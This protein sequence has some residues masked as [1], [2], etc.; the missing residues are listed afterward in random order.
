MTDFEMLQAIFD[1]IKGI[2]QDVQEIKQDNNARF[3]NL[4]NK[5]DNLEKEVNQNTI[6]VE[7]TIQKCID[8]IGE[9]YQMTSE[10]VD[11]L[12]IDSMN[13]KLN[14]VEMLCDLYK[15]ELMILKRKIG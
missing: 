3:D 10:K 2:K 14:K 6:A 9:G 15:E 11:R 8:V 4:E 12:N 7:T 1:E 5:F 13:S